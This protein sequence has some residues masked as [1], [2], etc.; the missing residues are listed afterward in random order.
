MNAE[1]EKTMG[2]FSLGLAVVGAVFGL[3]LLLATGMS[4]VPG[5]SRGLIWLAFV[6]PVLALAA[7]IAVLVSAFGSRRSSRA[8]AF[9][10]AAVVISVVMILLTIAT[11]RTYA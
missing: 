2:G 8:T 4:N 10:A 3:V 1:T 11:L 5:E 6:A 7:S 9:A